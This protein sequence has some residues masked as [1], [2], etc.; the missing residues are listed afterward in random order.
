MGGAHTSPHVKQYAAEPLWLRPWWW[1]WAG[2]IGLLVLVLAIGIPLLCLSHCWVHEALAQPHHHPAGLTADQGEHSTPASPDTSAD[3]HG[4][5]IPMAVI[6][7]L[8]LGSP[9]L[10]MLRHYRLRYQPLLH[11]WRSWFAPPL[12]PPPRSWQIPVSL[13]V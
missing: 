1:L 11:V 2:L 5:T 6:V 7:A 13:F 3:S 8:L 9:L 12:Q 10:V 4:H